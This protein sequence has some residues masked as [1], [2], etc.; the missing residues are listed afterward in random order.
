[1]T[2]EQAQVQAEQMMHHPMTMVGNQQGKFVIHFWL[3]VSRSMWADVAS[4]I[5]FLLINKL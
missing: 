3:G 2:N 4:L 1:M 5:D